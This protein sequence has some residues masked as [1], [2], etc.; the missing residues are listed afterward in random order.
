VRPTLNT[1]LIDSWQVGED[2]PLAVEMVWCATTKAPRK[3]K[4]A[5]I[6]VQEGPLR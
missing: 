2:K 1:V 6:I 4:D 3:M 5:L